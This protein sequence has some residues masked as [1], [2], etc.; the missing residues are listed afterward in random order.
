MSNK[1]DKLT[2]KLKCYNYRFHVKE[3][4]GNPDEKILY[5]YLPFLC[6]L[7]IRFSK[8]KVEIRSRV[9]YFLEFSSSLEFDFLF[10]AISVTALY[11]F[12]WDNIASYPYISVALLFILLHRVICF[13]KLET[14]KTIITRWLDELNTKD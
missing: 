1:I 6:F 8:E 3:G 14:L 7:K 11:A 5:V 10:Y 2:E 13:V 9:R 4:Y 12:A